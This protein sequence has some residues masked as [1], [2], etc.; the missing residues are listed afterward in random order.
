ML[1]FVDEIRPATLV[2]FFCK[3]RNSLT[4]LEVLL[5]KGKAAKPQFRFGNRQPGSPMPLTFDLPEKLLQD[6]D[7]KFF[8]LWT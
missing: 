6:C 4:A 3:F 2:M 1:F 5:L 7:R 8:K